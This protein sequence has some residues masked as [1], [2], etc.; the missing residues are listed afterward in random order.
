MVVISFPDFHPKRIPA[1]A[2][3][4]KTT[5]RPI[6][7][8]IEINSESGGGLPIELFESTRTSR[9]IGVNLYYLTPSD[10]MCRDFFA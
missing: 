6:R 1:I 2:G 9:E 3:R 8:A 5:P 4:T 7:R 10:P